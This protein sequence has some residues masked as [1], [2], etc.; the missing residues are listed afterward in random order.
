VKK[1]EVQMANLFNKDDRECS[2]V[3]DALENA[4]QDASETLVLSPEQQHHLAAC[5]DCQAAADERL[6]SRF[7]LRGVKPAVSPDAWFPARVMA[8]IAARESELRQSL[9]TWAVL[10]RL[11]ARLTWISALALLLMGTW[12]FESPRFARNP[13]NQP[14]SETLFESQQPQT[15]DDA[16]TGMEH[17]L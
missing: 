7:L 15:P 12:V 8:A 11:A 16:L 1:S 3:R 17:T 10:P 5:P 6:M 13:S 4:P 9:E 14:G 2:G